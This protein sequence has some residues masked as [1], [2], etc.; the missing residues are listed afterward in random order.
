MTQKPKRLEGSCQDSGSGTERFLAQW[1]SR[2]DSQTRG[3]AAIASPT[4]G[5]DVG[6]TEQV[7]VRNT[8]E[9][10]RPDR[11]SA[12]VDMRA[13]ERHVGVVAKDARWRAV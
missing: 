11:V 12:T 7:A 4:P 5:G 13:P 2:P 9:T 6:D 8:A 1:K 10:E 3:A